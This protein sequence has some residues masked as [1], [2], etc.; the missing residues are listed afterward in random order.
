[1]SKA[2]RKSR[3]SKPVEQ[4]FLSK[5]DFNRI[6]PPKYHV[7]F[8]ILTIIVLFLIFL[9]PLYFGGKTFQSGDIIASKSFQ[10]YVANHKEGYT[11][12]DPYIF[13]GMPAYVLAIG[14]KWFN[15]IYVCF[16]TL[17]E[18]FGAFF[19]VKYA[20]WSIY[21]II[22]AINA[23]FLVRYLTK[24]TLVGLFGAVATSFCTGIIVFLYIGHVTQLACIAFY[25]LIFLMLFKFQ[26]KVKLLDFFILVVALQITLQGFHVQIIFYTLF[27]IGIYYVYFFIRSFVKKEKELTKRLFKS[28]GGVA[29]AIII[30]L[31]IQSDNITQVYQYMPYST[32]G[33]ESIKD[34]VSGKVEKNTSGY[35]EYHTSWSFSP[36]EVLTFVVPS[37]Y[38]FGGSTYDGPLTNN[39]PVKVNTYFGQMPFVDVA[40]YMGVIVFVL[41]LFAVFTRWKDPVVQFLA[42]LAGIALLISFGKNFP[43]LFDPMFYYFPYFNKFRVPSMIL[44]LD[45][46]S[47]PVLAALGLMKIISLKKESNEKLKKIIRNL[48][49]T[50]SVIFVLSLLFNSGIGSWFAGRMTDYAD[51]IQQ[52][53]SR[54]AQM[55]K[56][57]SGY[58]SQMFTGDFLFAF[59]F[60]SLT[61]WGAYGY[62][63]SKLSS[64]SF[65]VIVILL[66]I[67]D[68]WRIDARGAVYHDNP[69]VKAAFQEPD[70]ISFIKSQKNKEPFRILNLKQDRSLGSLGDNEN[71]NAYFLVEDFYGYSAVKPRAFQDIMD[72]VGPVNKTVWRMLNVKY[73]ITNG[74]VPA[75]QFP[76][77]KEIYSSK[78][79]TVYEN[80][81]ALPRFYFVNSVQKK[82][83]ID[84]LNSM[85]DN[86]FD[87]KN[88]A[89]LEKQNLNVQPVDSADYAR[90]AN[91]TDE[92]IK[93]NVEAS[94][95]NFLFAGDTFVKG[96][97]AY[98]DNNQTKIYETNHGYLGIV[99]PKGKHTVIF[100]YAPTSF[101][102]SKYIALI[103]SSIVLL[104][105]IFAIIKEII[106][107]RKVQ[108]TSAEYN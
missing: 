30:A 44:V 41:A 94:G 23:F 67:I 89:Y 21:L 57:L 87:P 55:F 17:K 34:K 72:V 22:L 11:L 16:T 8:I 32:R 37:Y 15:M 59:A 5:F 66:T 39:Q 82:S 81:D 80:E 3:T 48:A 78:E 31:L 95:N 27:A 1:M 9:N 19:S 88:V 20:V 104:G 13:C 103:L 93:L 4:T 33:T 53:N 7:L 38:G 71:F 65:I 52:A 96:W 49:I 85:K 2:K 97:K 10:S 106:V 105:L 43:L 73:I 91:Y 45:Q 54:Q 35:Y 84:I 63:N 92:E 61:F 40:M 25:P 64:D 62:I 107:R 58:G 51:S 6:L 76:F 90:V 42:I 98:V 99:V 46:M 14:Y 12:W 70:Y 69:N 77:L 100:R 26:N 83:A 24:N 79:S 75:N 101:Y 56:A 108:E 86:G 50:F 28:V 102:V 18:I 74:K 36:E 60:I 29:L 68:L 47:F